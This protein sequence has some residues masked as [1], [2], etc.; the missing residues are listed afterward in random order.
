MYERTAIVAGIVGQRISDG[1]S[2]PDP[3]RDAVYTVGA[4][5]VAWAVAAVLGWLGKVVGRKRA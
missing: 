1:L 3:V 2:V 4:A 5:V